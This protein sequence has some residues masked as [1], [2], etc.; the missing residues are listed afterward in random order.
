MVRPGV[1]APDGSYGVLYSAQSLRGAFAETFLRQPGKTLLARD[2]MDARDYVVFELS[3]ALR[4]VRLYGRGLAMLGCTAEA[5]H[6]GLPYDLPDAW[7]KAL[8]EHEA[9][10]DGIA[11][12]ARH[13]DNEICYATTDRGQEALTVHTQE[14]DLD[15]DWFYRL[16]DYYGVGMAPAF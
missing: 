8:H 11:Y 12:R 6:G 7:S 10:P 4:C 1:N 5:T 3:R 16:C 15:R 9:T 2:H 14:L 13:D